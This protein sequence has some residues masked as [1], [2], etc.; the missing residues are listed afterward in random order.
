MKITYVY[1]DNN[2]PLYYNLGSGGI[3]SYEGLLPPQRWGTCGQC[4]YV[5]VIMQVK[6]FTVNAQFDLVL[7]T[8][9]TLVYGDSGAGKTY[10]C[11]LIGICK[12]M[13]T[14][15]TTDNKGVYVPRSLFELQGYMKT[16][17]G[18]VLV[19]DKME[20]WDVEDRVVAE[21]MILKDVYDKAE[22]YFVIMSRGIS[23]LHSFGL[24]YYELQYRNNI[25]TLKKVSK[26]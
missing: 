16:K 7:D 21:Q 14:I 4:S 2:K 19:I 9:L 1:T 23:E 6:G 11:K 8:P 20:Q 10:L 22:N 25:Y 13:N 5:E 26:L 15:R 24:H 17:P 12:D 18:S 3:L